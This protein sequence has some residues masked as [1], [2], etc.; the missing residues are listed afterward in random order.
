MALDNNQV[1]LKT[2]LPTVYIEPGHSSHHPLSYIYIYIF[3]KASLQNR[4]AAISAL[5]K[6]AVVLNTKATSDLYGRASGGLI[7]A[8]KD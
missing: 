5:M 3:S 2:I 6:E 1:L 8:N 7:V 4:K